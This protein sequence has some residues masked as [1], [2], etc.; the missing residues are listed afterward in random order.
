MECGAH[1][2]RGT[3]VN[4]ASA[5]DVPAFEVERIGPVARVRLIK[6]SDNILSNQNL[7][8]LSN[9][10]IELGR[11]DVR[12]ISLSAR[13]GDFC[14][15]RTPPTAA[16]KRNA[17]T[18]RRQ[19]LEPV[20]NLIGTIQTLPIPV[21]AVV[22]GRA[23]GMGCALAT[24]CDLTIAASTAR[25]RLPEME[26]NL[27]P[28]LAI[29]GM[30]RHIRTKDLAWLALTTDELDAASA[31]QLGLVNKVYAESAIEARAD[32]LL[33]ALAARSRDALMTVKQY[34]RALPSI[35]QALAPDFAAAL[36]ANVLASAD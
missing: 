1:S 32:T 9:A 26:R 8:D 14:A 31:M 36:L 17:L 25:F 11:T 22:T 33:E 7:A 10:M 30:A 3:H 5:E 34:L 13:A 15:G 6:G 27:P 4:T 19:Q 29:T 2:N 16:S 12:V 21:V 18:I 28:T 35:D 20:L 24:A 23:V